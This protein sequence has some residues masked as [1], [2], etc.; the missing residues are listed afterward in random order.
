MTREVERLLEEVESFRAWLAQG[1]PVPHEP[2]HACLAMAR[3]RI[4]ALEEQVESLKRAIKN[5]Q[6]DDL[7]WIEDPEKALALPREEF[8][9]SCR[10]YRDQ[11]MLERGE[12][13]VGQMTIAQLEEKVLDLAG[14]EPK[15][16]QPLE[17][18]VR[19][20]L[21][22]YWAGEWDLQ[23]R[24]SWDNLQAPILNLPGGKELWRHAETA[25][26]QEATTRGLCNLARVLLKE[27]DKT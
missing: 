12:L 4:V 7:C 15:L 24:L 26:Y 13:N 11:I 17:N 22:F 2:I 21:L 27:I 20:A 25:G 1:G 5:K 6:G 9:E 10:R 8:M 18:F 23:K 14:G 19:L 3:G 16:R